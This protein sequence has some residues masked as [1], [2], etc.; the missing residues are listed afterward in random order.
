ME[1]CLVQNTRLTIRCTRL[2]TLG[3]FNRVLLAKLG[4][5]VSGLAHP[6]AGKLMIVSRSFD[7]LEDI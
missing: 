7:Q 6:Q 5:N 2:A 1:I 3:I 4:Y